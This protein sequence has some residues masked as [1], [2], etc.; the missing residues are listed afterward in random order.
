MSKQEPEVK[1]EVEELAADAATVEGE[2]EV[3]TAEVEEEIVAEVTEE[4]EAVEAEE[5]AVLSDA[6]EDVWVNELPI[7]GL[8]SP[9]VL[10]ESVEHHVV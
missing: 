1:A 8:L 10:P 2:P 6:K 9:L 4:P 3:D 5:V 7:V